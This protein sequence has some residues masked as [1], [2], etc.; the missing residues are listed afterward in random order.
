MPKEA[1]TEQLKFLTELL[2]LVW[3]SLLAV[4]GGTIGLL[5]GPSDLVRALFATAG[6]I[7]S[8]GLGVMIERLIRK[9]RQLL[10]QLEEQ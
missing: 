3:I 7:T 10:A 9:M 8:I 6:I 1:I 5:F 2:R 4:G